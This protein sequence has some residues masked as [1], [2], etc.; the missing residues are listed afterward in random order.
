MVWSA[1]AGHPLPVSLHEPGTQ[2]QMSRVRLSHRQG[3]FPLELEGKTSGG[4]ADP[5][6]Q[7]A[8]HIV[9]AGV[10]P[11]GGEDGVG[12]ILDNDD[13]SLR[14]FPDEI[15]VIVAEAVVAAKI[16]DADFLQGR[17]VKD[18]GSYLWKHRR[19]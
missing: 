7:A 19:I 17:F 3:E 8:D 4:Y 6:P 2:G 1:V 16:D 5:F 10:H 13:A 12:G 15:P 11:V 18:R 14:A 9:A